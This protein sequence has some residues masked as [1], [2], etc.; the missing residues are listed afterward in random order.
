[1]SQLTACLLFLVLVN[2][3]EAGGGGQTMLLVLHMSVRNPTIQFY[4]NH[5]IWQESSHAF[6]MYLKA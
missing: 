2:F 6:V 4:I 1:M 3:G 5:D